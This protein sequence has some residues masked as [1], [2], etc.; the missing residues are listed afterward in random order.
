MLR[1]GEGG[2]GFEGGQMWMGAIL[3]LLAETKKEIADNEM[4]GGSPS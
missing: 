2:R 4:R 1:W 3:A